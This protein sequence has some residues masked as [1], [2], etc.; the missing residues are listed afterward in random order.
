MHLR[1]ITPDDRHEIADLIYAS[2]NTWYRLHGMPQI[3][4]G[5]PKLTEVFYDVY[6]A[7]DP[8]C[9]VVAEH[10]ETRRLMGCCFYHP[11]KYHMAL[12]IMSVHPNYAGMG[13][14][15]ALL[16]QIIDLSSAQGYKSLR[17]TQSA[18]NLD[19]FSLYNR[20]GFVPRCAYQDMFIKVPPEG[21][22]GPVPGAEYIRNAN[23]DDVSAMAALELD[24][25]GISR[26]EDYRFCIQN[27]L[28]LMHTSIY[29]NSLGEID[30]FLMSSSHPAC[31]M[32]GPGVCRTEDQ[33][34]ALIAR[35]LDLNRGRSP[36]FL[37]PVEQEKI[38]RQMY[39]WGARNCELHFCQVRGNFQPF[40]GINMPTFILETA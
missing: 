10:G 1:S 4:K 21:I 18:L 39:A 15:G 7:I 8:G 6:D 5:G 11:R 22:G 9:A 23:L 35:E 40:N 27:K 33:A 12:G 14:G 2:F 20:A 31:N 25:S 30:G 16:Q 36:V 34:I 26:E 29:E 38:V 24:V 19:S 32:L 3:F 13:V 28:G 37:V 17:L